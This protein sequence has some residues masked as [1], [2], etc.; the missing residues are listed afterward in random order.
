MTVHSCMHSPEYCCQSL[1]CSLTP[2]HSNLWQQQKR[3]LLPLLP[4]VILKLA[5]FI[6][7]C[8]YCFSLSLH[9][10]PSPP[11]SLL[12]S[13]TQNT[14]MVVPSCWLALIVSPSHFVYISFTTRALEETEPLF[15]RTCPDWTTS[16]PWGDVQWIWPKKK[17]MYWITYSSF[18]APLN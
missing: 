13:V 18:N 14:S 2:S 5:L 1:I 12:L 16:G 4:L 9:P 6:S 7:M 17:K 8:K 11:A 15:F 3:V 10:F